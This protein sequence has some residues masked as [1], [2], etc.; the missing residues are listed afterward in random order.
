MKTYLVIALI[1]CAVLTAA[2]VSAA[3]CESLASLKLAN[4][5]IVSAQNVSAG[6]FVLPAGSMPQQGENLGAFNALPAFC[7]VQGVIQPSS[8][9]HIEFEVWLPASG[10]NGKYQGTSN[11]GFAGGINFWDLAESVSN[12]YASSSTDT[13]HKAAV[14]NAEWAPGHPEKIV[15]YGYLA[16][17]ETVENAKAVIRAFYGVNPKGSYFSGCSGGGRQALMEAQ[18]YPADYDGIIAGAPAGFMT[19]QLVSMTWNIQAT[20]ANPASYIHA[21]KLPA[22]EAAALAACDALDGVKDGIIDD[23]TKCRFDPAKLL[24]NGPETDSCLTEPQVTALKKI[25]AGPRNPKGEQLYPG[26]LPGGETGGPY[27]WSSFITGPAPGRSLACVFSTQVNKYML[28]QDP[29]WDFRTFNFERDV[30]LLDDRLGGII[31]ATDPNLKAFKGHGGKLII[32]HGWSDPAEAPLGTVNYY[33]N[34]VSKMRQK[35]TVDFVRLY[36]VPG[37]QHCIGGPGPDSFGGFTPGAP[38]DPQHSMSMALERWVEKGVAPEEIIA[39]KYKTDGQPASGVVRT[40]PL[41]PYP[42]VAKYKGSGST[43]DAAN[44]TCVSPK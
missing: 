22:I 27:G 21:S 1:F 40:R 16:I 13:G 12:G 43:D 8:D 20:E 15:D 18:R 31:N 44:F 24:C 32:Y 29:T 17:H 6:T 14:L 4:T 33:E 36:M 37:M 26:L 35:N 34:V 41:C 42:Q 2:P 19:H 39:T 3:T 10:W 28:F 7:R 5:T 30:K 25:Y 11:G 9:S 23:P 38:A